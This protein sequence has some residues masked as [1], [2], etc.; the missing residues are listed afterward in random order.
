MMNFFSRKITL[1]FL[2][3]L[4]VN[5]SKAQHGPERPELGFFGGGMYYLGDLNQLQNFRNTYLTGSLFLRQ[6]FNKRLN[7][8]YMVSYGNVSGNDAHTENAWERNRNLSF[9]SRIIET[10]AILEINFLPFEPGNKKKYYATPYLMYGLGLFKMNPMARSAND[11]WYEL[12]PLGTEGQGSE[13]ND[14]DKYK[15]TQFCIPLGIGFKGNLTE[16]LI[17]GF[18]YT[19]RKTFTDY[20]DDVSGN[21]VD[22]D[23]LSK[24]NGPLAA[25]FADRSLDNSS[26]YFTG[27]NRGN[28]NFKDWYATAGMY[29]AIKLGNKKECN[30]GFGR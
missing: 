14:R 24:Y 11:E 1:A 19:I 27:S 25:S 4:F 23:L 28:S 18:E 17:L 29:L 16:H 2:L 8:R 5:L 21:Y 10:S 9:Y 15:L 12:Q 30:M 7:M 22:P 13:L 26:T 20:L 6:N 3:A